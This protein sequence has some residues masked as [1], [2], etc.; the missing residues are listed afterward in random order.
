MTVIFMDIESHVKSWVYVIVM[1][2]TN[3]GVII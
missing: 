1:I 3:S 2:L